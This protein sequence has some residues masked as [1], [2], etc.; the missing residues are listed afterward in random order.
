VRGE[1][2][3]VAWAAREKEKSGEGGSGGKGSGG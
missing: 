1:S 3:R 2:E